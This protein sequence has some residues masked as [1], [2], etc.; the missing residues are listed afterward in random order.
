MEWNSHSKSLHFIDK[1]KTKEKKNP[2]RDAYK[3]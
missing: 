1:E 2:I 3:L